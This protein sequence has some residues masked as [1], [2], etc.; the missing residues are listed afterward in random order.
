MLL[1][2]DDSAGA[3]AGPGALRLAMI[4]GALALAALAAWSL[5]G[6]APLATTAKATRGDAAAVVYATGVVE[7]VHWAQIAA[8]Q[9]RRIIEVCKCEGQPVKAGEVLARLDDTEERARLRELEARLDQLK[10]DAARIEGLVERAAASRTSLDEAHTQIQEF[11]ARIAAQRARIEDLKLKAPMDGVV[12]RRDGEVGEIAGAGAGDA[13]LWVGRPKP[14]RVVAEVNE[15]DVFNIRLGQ[16]ALLRHEGNAGAPLAATVGSVTPKGDPETKTFRVYLGL[17]EDTPLMIG[18]NVEANIVVDEARD[19]VLAPA[20]A[21]SNGRVQVI[22][23]GRAYWRKVETGIRGGA[24][25]EIRS[26]LE[27]GAQLV[28]PPLEGLA[29]G[30]AVRARPK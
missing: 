21:L 25:V 11:E 29:D 30:A 19:A 23:G 9:R 5:F 27:A 12:L 3:A 8:L 18:M 17:P 28:S 6:R 26:G 20:E 15:E 14:L 2:E 22:E 1:S 4:A 7:P 16:R 24:L 13:I 10:A